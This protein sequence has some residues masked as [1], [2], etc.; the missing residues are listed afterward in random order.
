MRS[1][2]RFAWS[3]KAA[4]GPRLPGEREAPAEWAGAGLPGEVRL[5]RVAEPVCRVKVR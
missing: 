2:A 4:A 3:L 1:A 5:D